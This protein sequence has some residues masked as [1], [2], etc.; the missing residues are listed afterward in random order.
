MSANLDGCRKLAAPLEAPD[1]S[2]TQADEC[3]EFLE[4]EQDAFVFVVL[5]C[6]GGP[7]M[8]DGSVARLRQIQI[9]PS[10]VALPI[11]KYPHLGG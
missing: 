10:S 5:E 6:H 3:F 8:V 11:D 7:L 1:K 9:A 2:A 4:G